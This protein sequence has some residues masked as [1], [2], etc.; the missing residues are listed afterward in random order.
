MI[1]AISEFNLEAMRLQTALIYDGVILL[2]ETFKQLGLEQIEPTSIVC[3]GNDTMWEKGMSISNFMRNVSL[4]RSKFK[5]IICRN[6][7]LYPP[8]I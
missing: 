5:T 6:V 3:M 2:T 4:L 8:L 7:V 1:S